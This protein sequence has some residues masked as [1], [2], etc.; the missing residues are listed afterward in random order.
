MSGM[1]LSLRSWTAPHVPHTRKSWNSPCALRSWT[2][3]HTLRSWTAL[4]LQNL[5][6]AWTS[7]FHRS[8]TKMITIRL[9]AKTTYT[10]EK[11]D[12][13]RK[14]SSDQAISNVQDMG[15]NMYA[16]KC[17]S[18]CD[19]DYEISWNIYQVSTFVMV[20]MIF[21]LGSRPMDH[22]PRILDPLSK[23]QYP[24]I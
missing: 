8:R 21:Y 11:D 6:S 14:Q 9:K 23:T 2:A 12:P 10:K 7:V 13:L 3:A 16:N 1:I 5:M 20:T 24:W 19:C 4:Y 15:P 17:K 18:C 22:K